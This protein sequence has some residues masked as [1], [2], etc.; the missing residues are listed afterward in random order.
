MPDLSRLRK[1]EEKIDALY[2]HIFRLTQQINHV[3]SNLDEEN[4]GKEL[5]QKVNQ[6]KKGAE[7][8]QNI[9]QTG[10]KCNECQD[11]LDAIKDIQQTVTKCNE[12]K[13]LL[14]AIKVSDEEI[15][16]GDRYISNA[17]FR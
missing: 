3:L 17:R 5:L 1:P 15:D 6:T 10:I 2:Q 14:D 13:N 11:L 4:L 12:C 7:Q 9:Q 8:Q 16:V